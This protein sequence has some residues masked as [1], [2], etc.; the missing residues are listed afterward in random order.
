MGGSRGPLTLCEHE[1]KANELSTRNQ[2]Q[3][4]V[5]E[6]KKKGRTTHIRVKVGATMVVASITNE[7][8]DRVRWLGC[9][10][11]SD[12]AEHKR[13]CANPATLQTAK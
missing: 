10:N 4:I 6:V 12:A 13:V 5:V 11:N 7:A 9:F 2:L 3:R 8:P 1:G